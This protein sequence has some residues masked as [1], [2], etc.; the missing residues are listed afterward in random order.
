MVGNQ[1]VGEDRRS[2]GRA[3]GVTVAFTIVGQGIAIVLL[4]WIVGRW[5]PEPS[6]GGP[7]RWAG[8]GLIVPGVA[9]VADS[10][11]RFVRQGRG[12]PAPIAP[13]DR[14]V[15]SGLYRRVR[16]PMYVGVLA[17]IIG[18]AVVWGRVAVLGHAAVLWLIFHLFVTL[19]EEPHLRRQ[20]GPA[21]EA[22]RREVPR[23]IPRLRAAPAVAS[24]PPIH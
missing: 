5:L 12:T 13:P 18:E 22:Y 23:W 21:Y 8:L 19:Y 7:W 9:M 3:T 20:F 10:F 16:N 17:T 24:S 14:L 6:F 4:P 1:D 15:V 11:V 2:H